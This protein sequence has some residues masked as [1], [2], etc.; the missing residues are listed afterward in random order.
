[1]IFSSVLKAFI[2]LY[3]DGYRFRAL[4]RVREICREKKITWL[5]ICVKNYLLHKFGC[6][7][8]IDAR[9]STKAMFM[10]TTG[11][12]IGGGGNNRRWS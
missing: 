5:A 4:L 11:V 8:S 10:H 12:V 7:L 6:E 3:G 9:I 1:M 2:P